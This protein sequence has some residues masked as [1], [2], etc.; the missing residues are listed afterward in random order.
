V[1]SK[2]PTFPVGQWVTFRTQARSRILTLDI[3]GIRA[4]EFTGLD[5]DRGYIGLQ[6]EGKSFDF[7]NVRVRELGPTEPA[8][9]D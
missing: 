2:L 8:K 5:P 4:W 1:K 7:R 3:N 6:A 9:Q